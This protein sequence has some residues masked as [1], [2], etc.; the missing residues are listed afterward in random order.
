MTAASTHTVF[1]LLLSKRFE[2][3]NSLA[4]SKQY[5]IVAVEF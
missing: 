4:A 2:L 3:F 5:F 1:V